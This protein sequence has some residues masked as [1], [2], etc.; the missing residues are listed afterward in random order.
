MAAYGIDEPLGAV[1]LDHL[2]PIS[3]GGDPRAVANLWPEA[4]E[5]PDGA[6]VKDRLELRL[7]QLV[8]RHQAELATAQAAIATDWV[9]AYSRY[10]G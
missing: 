6:R 5:G 1:E 7:L 9:A 4:W 8:C 3:L 2:I 10:L